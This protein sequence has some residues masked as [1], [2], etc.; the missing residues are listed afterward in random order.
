MFSLAMVEKTD[1]KTGGQSLCL[2]RM[3][4]HVSIPNEET[5]YVRKVASLL[6]P[7]A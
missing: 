3:Y 5:V 2:V 1:G 7:F 6:T 4:V